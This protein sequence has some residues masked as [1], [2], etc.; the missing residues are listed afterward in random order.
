M[1]LTTGVI[2]NST[3]RTG[4]RNC[5]EGNESLFKDIIVVRDSFLE[6][7]VAVGFER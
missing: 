1:L 5:I 3:E 7:L 6:K 2:N 4:C